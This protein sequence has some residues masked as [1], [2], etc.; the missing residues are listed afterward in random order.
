MQWR[1]APPASHLLILTGK[2][3]EGL[4]YDFSFFSRRQVVNF[5]AWE[6]LPGEAIAP[7]PDIVGERYRVLEAIAAS[8]EPLIIL[9]GM[10]ACLQKLIPPATF[11]AL[12]LSLQVG[13][14]R[15]FDRLVV[16][17]QEMGYRQA[18]VAAD[19]GEFAVRGGII[20]L[21]PVASPDPFPH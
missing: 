2:Q 11:S 1:S 4:F 16:Q 7:S 12:Y 21:F 8:R 9:T 13:A 14:I 5:P 6:T 19:K 3:Q 15:D 20:D 18:T 17:L 10:Q